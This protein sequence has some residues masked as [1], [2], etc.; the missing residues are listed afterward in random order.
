M[1][2]RQGGWGSIH[3]SKG[4]ASECQPRVIWTNRSSVS[5][6]L[7]RCKSSGSTQT[8]WVWNSWGFNKTPRGSW[9][10]AR[11]SPMGTIDLPR[12]LPAS[13]SSSTAH[14]IGFIPAASPRSLHKTGKHEACLVPALQST[15]SPPGG[16][17]AQGPPNFLGRGP[18]SWPISL[19]LP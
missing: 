19:V 4:L 3:T 14:R 1:G 13:P 8:Y 2:V 15:H 12:S 6:N 10:D 11:C 17:P 18:H 5:W 9:C 7:L 16:P